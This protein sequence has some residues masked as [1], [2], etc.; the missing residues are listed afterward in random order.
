[1]NK[2]EIK[3]I[4]FSSY[5]EISGVISMIIGVLYG[6]VGIILGMP[7]FVSVGLEIINILLLHLIVVPLMYCFAGVLVGI[8]TYQPYKAFMKLRKGMVFTYIP[9]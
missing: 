3:Y 5:V 1:M 8:M 2:I 7:N 4:S 9:K 6:V